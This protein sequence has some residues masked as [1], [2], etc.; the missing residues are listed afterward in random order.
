MR[1]SE[2]SIFYISMFE[3]THVPTGVC[4]ATPLAETRYQV[5]HIN[6]S[7]SY[8]TCIMKLDGY[9]LGFF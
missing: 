6:E 7:L 5:G 1:A 3:L 8:C 2:K 9:V 4:Q